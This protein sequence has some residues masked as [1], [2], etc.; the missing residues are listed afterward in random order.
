MYDTLKKAGINLILHQINNGFAKEI[1]EEKEARKLKY[2]IAPRGNHRTI[3]QE[4]S[5]FK[6]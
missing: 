3:Y 6:Q 5:C 4:R 1:L 2:Q